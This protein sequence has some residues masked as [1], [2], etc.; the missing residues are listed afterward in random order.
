LIPPHSTVVLISGLPGDVESETAYNELL[1]SWLEVVS[2]NEGL[3][4]VVVLCDS[5]EKVMIPNSS[6]TNHPVT[7]NVLP[8]NRVNFLSLPTAIGSTTNPVIIIAW[9]H[10]GRQGSVPVFHV[11]GPRITLADFKSLAEKISGA[12]S[13]WILE[14][15][16]SGA[17]ASALAGERRQIISSENDTAF[18]SDPIAM[19]LITKIAQAKPAIAFDGLADELGAATVKWYADRNLART[20]EPT[21]WLGKSTPR[22]LATATE[23]HALASA[24]EGGPKASTNTVEKQAAISPLSAELPSVWKEIK[25][26]D[27]KKYPDSDGVILR[28]HIGYTI[29]TSPALSSEEDEFIQVLTAEGKR[30]GDFD[31]S[32]SPP[33]EDITFSD[34]EVLSPAGKLTRLSAE[35]IRESHD[36]SVGDYQAGRRKFFSLPGVVPGAILHVRHRTQWKTFPM[37]HVS[38]TIPIGQEL[39]AVE[40]AIEVSV[41][42][43]SPFH[44]AFEGLGNASSAA[45]QRDPVI[46]QSNYGTT[47]EWK[48][49][50]LPPRQHE[51]LSP[52]RSHSELL[53]STFPDWGG[54]ADWYG[55]ISKLTDE[56]TPEIAARASNV[57]ATAKSDREKVRALYN[58]VTSLRYVAVPLGINSYRPHAAANVLEHQFGDCKDKANLFNAL[59]HSQKI[60]AHLVLVPRFSQAHDDIPGLSFNHAISRVSLGGE[61]MW[62][63][64]TDD[65][66]RFGMLPPGDPGRKVLVVDGEAKALTQLPVAQARDHQFKLRGQIDC[67]KPLEALPATFTATAHGFPDYELRSAAREVKEHRASVPL[68][69]ARFHPIAGSFA[70]EKQTSTAV[71]ALDEDFSWEAEGTLI[72]LSA[73]V[74]DLTDPNAPT[75]QRSNVF[76]IRAPVWLPREWDFA[77]HSRHGPLFLNSG[78]P[79]SLDEEFEF[80][81]PAKAKESALPGRLENGKD[82]FH[83]SLGWTRSANGNLMVDFRAEL[84]RG[85][86]SAAETLDFQQQL[87]ALLTALAGTA[88]VSASP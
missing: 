64:T 54:F 30:F 49:E 75:L 44:F 68:L 35:A 4:S 53:I 82:P 36:E 66:C 40:S 42:K 38:L 76:T 8:A 73:P 37:P 9:G 50:D 78:Y 33:Y 65:V 67:S 59:L 29:G 52:P 71:S 62:L 25:R 45:S 20:E 77:L 48:F 46:K 7:P 69:S 51:I 86:L 79:L 70:L 19:S 14:F 5:P 41:P 74:P 80:K 18:T 10:G 26:A 21:L 24:T 39:P 57:V 56:V 27:A 47:Y 60:A 6:G 13:R 43:D 17:F 81:V 88:V 12:E 83:W 84:G 58:Y 16:G 2:L 32:Y 31:I 87:R 34:C 72:G 63:D 1:E 61:T 22:L 3:E 11:R 23:E 15:R 55:R 28:R 85:E